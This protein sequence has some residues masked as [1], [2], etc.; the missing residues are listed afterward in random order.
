M[1]EVGVPLASV[2]HGETISDERVLI[3][4][5][6]QGQRMRGWVPIFQ[7]VEVSRLMEISTLMKKTPNRRS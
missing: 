6:L 2:L 1:F 3:I 4:I 5:S 7:K